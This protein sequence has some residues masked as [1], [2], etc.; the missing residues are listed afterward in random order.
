MSEERYCVLCH[1]QVWFGAYGTTKNHVNYTP[2]PYYESR[3][4][5]C[6]DCIE[7]LKKLPV[8]RPEEDNCVCGCHPS[9][10]PCNECNCGKDGKSRPTPDG[11]CKE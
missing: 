5:V 2:N 7:V 8:A 6:K 1:N 4:K 9:G 11:E 3:E 10:E